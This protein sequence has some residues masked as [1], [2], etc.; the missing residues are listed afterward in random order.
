MASN[1]KSIG[2]TNNKK[3][4]GKGVI[5]QLNSVLQNKNVIYNSIVESIVTY[6]SKTCVLNKRE[7]ETLLRLETDIVIA[8]A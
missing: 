8:V 7:S 4:G 1:A 3:V 2:N 6:R 5:R